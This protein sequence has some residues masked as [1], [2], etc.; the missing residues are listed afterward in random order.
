MNRKVLDFDFERRCSVTLNYNH[1]YVCMVC[2][3]FFQGRSKQSPAYTHAVEADHCVFMNLET[4][5]VYCL[6]DGYE[7]KD[8]TLSDIQYALHPTFQ[9][10]DILNIPKSNTLCRDVHGKL[11]LPGYI[12]LNN[13]KR[14]DYINVIVQALV[15][16]K[17]IRSFFSGARKQVTKNV[18]IRLSIVLVA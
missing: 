1:V 5:R 10:E 16:V 2:G 3:K 17:P 11:Y 12:G 6:P 15:R 13:L 8:T 14:T 9:E 4:A 7:V 18:I